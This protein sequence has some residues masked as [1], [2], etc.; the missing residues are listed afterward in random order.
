MDPILVQI[1]PLAIR[2]YGALIALG[3]A[4]GTIW[5]VRVAKRRGIDPE[6][7]YD[8]APW[9]VLGGLIGARLVFV[10]TSPHAIFDHGGSLWD[11]FAIWKGGGS[12]HG[13]VLGV[14]LAAWIYARNHRLEMWRYL[15]LLTPVGVLGIIGGRIGNV[16]NG[17][18]TTGRL[19]GLPIGVTW[20][21][22]GAETFGAVGRLVFG[23]GL[24]RAYSGTCDL[25]SDVAWSQCEA[26]GGAIVRGPVHFTQAYGALVGLLLIP[27]LWWAFRVPRPPGFVFW[28]F[29]LWYSVLRAVIEEPFRDNPLAVR[30]YLSEGTDALGIGL[31]TLTQ[32]ASTFLIALA[33]IVLHRMRAP[34]RRPQRGSVDRPATRRLSHTANDEPLHT[35]FT[36]RG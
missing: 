32:I 21:T 8:M 14:A 13:G 9:L 7:L 4:V 29:V 18:D 33:W 34:T 31:L 15:D 17:D 3:A 20:P 22:P 27:L 10:A 5:S 16:M 1:G 30:L 12:I 35:T 36:K 6:P 2:W 28:Q 11:V 23:D 26:L 24:W 19:T 25:G